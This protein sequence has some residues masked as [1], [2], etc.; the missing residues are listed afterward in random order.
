MATTEAR[1]DVLDETLPDYK[2]GVKRTMDEYAKLDQ[3]DDALIKYKASLGLGTGEKDLSDPNDPRD[4]LIIS[5]ALYSPGRDPVKLDLTS[6]GAVEALK[7]QPF[8][9]K[10]GAKYSIEVT[11]KVQHNILCGLQY[12]QTVKRAGF[13]SKEREMIGSYAPNTDKTPQYVK[14]FKEE[15]AP[16]GMLLRGKYSVNSIFID[17]DKKKHLEFDWSLEVA[18][19]W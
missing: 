1:Q 6:A 9:I 13:S 18:K 19:D 5:L 3:D 7:K 15:E 4:C 17:D 12:L 2:I 11:F 16:S 8:R 14:R 10:E